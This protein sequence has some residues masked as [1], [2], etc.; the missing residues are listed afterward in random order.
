M[1][2]LPFDLEIRGDQKP[3]Q[4]AVVRCSVLIRQLAGKRRVYEGHWNGR[5]VIVKVFDGR[6]RG[7][8]GSRREIRGL[9][10]LQQRGISAPRIL[11][12]GSDRRGGTVLVLEKIPDGQD[13][14]DFFEDCRD[15]QAKKAM[16]SKWIDFVAGMHDKGIVQA[17]LHTG[18]FMTAAGVLYALDPGTMRLDSAPVEIQTGLGQLAEMICAMPFECRLEPEP[19]LRQYCQARGRSCS[20]EDLSLLRRYIRKAWDGAVRRTLKKTMRNTRR[21][22]FL[23]EGD[24]SGMFQQKDWTAESACAFMRR[25]DRLMEEGQILKRGNA[26]FVSRVR[27][28]GLDAAVKR[29]NH[30]GLLH[31]LRHTIKGSRARKCWLEGH[32]LGQL[33]LACARPLAFVEQRRH[34]LLWRSYL[35]SEFLEGPLL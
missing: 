3:S 4:P 6:L 11:L 27:I 35:V 13:L 29:Y 23:R 24:L 34:G 1:E 28:G 16:Y 19:Y 17:D 26:C 9:T 33:G 20:E 8:L 32:R 18:N 21:F 31:S 7:R 15:E 14:A 25:I 5:E 12:T 10:V 30:K 2:T 22:M